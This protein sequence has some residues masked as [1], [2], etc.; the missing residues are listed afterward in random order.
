MKDQAT[1]PATVLVVD[2]EQPNRALLERLL[3]TDG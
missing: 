2:D 1:S 3:A